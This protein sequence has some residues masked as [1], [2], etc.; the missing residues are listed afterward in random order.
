MCDR[1]GIGS[2]KNN[3]VL[4][5][6]IKQVALAVVIASLSVSSV[7]AHAPREKT[8]IG[9]DLQANRLPTKSNL[10]ADFSL[11][12][13]AK[14]NPGGVSIFAGHRWQDFGAE[15]GFTYMGY[16]KETGVLS[17]GNVTLTGSEKLTNSNIYLDGNYYFAIS[18]EFDLKALVGI[19]YLRTRVD[20]NG[21]L[22][23]NGVTV[24]NGSDKNTASRAGIRV[25][26]G[27][28]YY[29]TNHFSSSLML[30]YQA[31]N[32]VYKNMKT[33]ALGFAYHI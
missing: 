24:A 11:V 4:T 27:G 30:K 6:N 23:V 33:L 2:L 20:L 28:Q 22:V 5:M 1:L 32:K 14:K 13:K 31:G 16:H 7:Y 17:N 26:L 3:G 18:P 10:A 15:L 21:K 29:F 9:V 12:N 8:F 19:G 25:G